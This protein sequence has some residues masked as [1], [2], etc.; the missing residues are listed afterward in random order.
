MVKVC[1]CIYNM[2][3]NVISDALA[4]EVNV[5]RVVFRKVSQEIVLVMPGK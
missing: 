5:P 2:N 1:S 3:L 4:R